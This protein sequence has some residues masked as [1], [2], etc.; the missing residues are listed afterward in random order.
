MKGVL[1]ELSH[2]CRCRLASEWHCSS[3]REQKSQRGQVAVWRRPRLSQT[4]GKSVVK[5][6]RLRLSEP[7]PQNVFA[8]RLLRKLL[9]LLS[10]PHPPQVFLKDFASAIYSF[11]LFWMIYLL[12]DILHL[13]ARDIQIFIMLQILNC[14]V[15]DRLST[16]G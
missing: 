8:F 12:P 9:W 13:S 4:W 14:Q 5:R 11:T 1:W 3:F 2:C 16:I 15:P 10:L 6:L 7:S